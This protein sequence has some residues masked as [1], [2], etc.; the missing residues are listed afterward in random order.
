MQEVTL[1][2]LPGD[3][4]IWTVDEFLEKSEEACRLAAIEL[5]RK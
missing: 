2:I 5:N 4:E 1:Q 3:E